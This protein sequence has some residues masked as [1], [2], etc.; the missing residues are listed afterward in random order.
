[1]GAVIDSTSIDRSLA[2]MKS[3]YCKICLNK[4]GQFTDSCYNFGTGFRDRR[5]DG[6]FGGLV[7]IRCKQRIC[8][9]LN[10]VSRPHRQ[11]LLL[12]HRKERSLRLQVRNCL[13]LV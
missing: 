9:K 2:L 10:L 13:T 8:E 7:S 4:I 3:A 11:R 5:T 6:T 1:M 12:S